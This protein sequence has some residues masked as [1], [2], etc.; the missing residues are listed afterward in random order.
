MMAAALNGMWCQIITCIHGPRNGLA[1]HIFGHKTDT[2]LPVGMEVR[3]MTLQAQKRLI[4]FQE[5][6]C[7]GPVGF[8]TL[9]AAL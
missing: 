5:V 4:L 3:F 9:K 7:H 6:V 2:S 8:M 1:G